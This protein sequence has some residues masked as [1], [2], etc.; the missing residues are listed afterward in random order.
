MGNVVQAG[1]KMN[2]ARHLMGSGRWGY[3]MGEAQIYDRYR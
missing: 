3:R 1:N 2:P